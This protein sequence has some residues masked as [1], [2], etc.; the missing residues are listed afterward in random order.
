MI[1]G[2][3]H[4]HTDGEDGRQGHSGA[5]ACIS[6]RIVIPA[7]S[8]PRFRLVVQLSNGSPVP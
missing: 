3:P 8:S 1:R 4:A 7:I 5:R 2:L 6:G